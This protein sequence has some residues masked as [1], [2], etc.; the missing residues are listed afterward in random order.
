MIADMNQD[1]QASIMMIYSEMIYA[2]MTTQ[3]QEELRQALDV[4]WQWL[5][6]E[7]ISGDDLYFHLDDG[8]EFGGIFI[9][10]QMDEKEANVLKWDNLSY[11]LSYINFLAYKKEGQ[12]YFPAMIEN[13][14]DTIYDVFL[15]NL[16][17]I[18]SEWL[19]D[20]P[21]ISTFV[22]TAP[23]SKQVAIDFLKENRLI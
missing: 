22:G 1:N 13:V 18:A 19:D 7:V 5:E 11:A 15:E 14:D 8:T 20:L 17:V 2:S 21:V 16:N 23:V 10:M 12:V 6:G 9:L 3:Y 4:C